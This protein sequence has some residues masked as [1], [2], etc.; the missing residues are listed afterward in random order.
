MKRK[1]FIFGTIS[2]ISI[3]AIALIVFGQNNGNPQNPQNRLVDRFEK[4]I[5]NKE[6]KFIGGRKTIGGEQRK[7]HSILGWKLHEDYVFSN[8]SDYYT[9]EDAIADMKNYIEGIN[10]RPAP[11]KVT[12]LTNL[13][14]EAYLETGRNSANIKLR[15]GKVVMKVS[16]TNPIIAKRFAKYFVREIEKRDRGEP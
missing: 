10:F 8:V 15:K 9:L 14:D 3:L 11:A 6:P 13:A 7:D 1:T 16:A 2:M 12:K 4:L 5:K